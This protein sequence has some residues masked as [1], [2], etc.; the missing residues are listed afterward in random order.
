MM[1]NKKKWKQRILDKKKEF[2]HWWF[3]NPGGPPVFKLH[4]FLGGS[5]G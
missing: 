4:F 2:Q 1:R 3:T 5:G